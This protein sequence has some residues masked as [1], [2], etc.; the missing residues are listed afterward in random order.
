MEGYT[1]PTNSSNDLTLEEI[2][3]IMEASRIL[4][5]EAFKITG[6]EPTLRNDLPEI[7][8]KLRSIG[9]YVSM[10]TNASLL[11]KHV[12]KLAEYGLGHINVSLH[13]M[14]PLRF[15]FITKSN[16]YDRVIANIRLAREYDIPVKI[17]YVVLKDTS[18]DDVE[19]LIKFASEV[20]AHVQFIELHPVGKAVT[21]FE[22]YHLPGWRIL[23]L[24]SDRIVEIKYR[25]G[26]HNR[27]ILVLDNGVVVE[28]VG[29]VGNHLFCAGCT[30]IRVTY[31]FKLIPCLNWKGPL[32]DV[33]SRLE[34]VRDR[35]EKI[36]IVVDAIREAN[37]LRRPSVLW[38]LKGPPIDLP[39]RSKPIRLGLPKRSGE[40]NFGSSSQDKYINAIIKSWG[41]YN[42]AR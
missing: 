22:Q 8:A 9:A 41:G 40:L 3:L 11:H 7:V 31:D 25:L 26:L 32:I 19:R 15:R 38:P 30:R 34:K 36:K 39:K 18:R 10:T 42:E 21:V 23:E 28:I 20:G 6:G 27:P 17:N 2:E 12:S 35:E 24:I 16:L 14:D 29:P 13:S 37:S 5:I 4:G 1:G 33:R